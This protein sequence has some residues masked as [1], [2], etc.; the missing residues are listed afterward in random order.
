MDNLH[1]IELEF[2]SVIALAIMILIAMFLKEFIQ[3]QI[4]NIFNS[5]GKKFKRQRETSEIVY[6]NLSE[7][8][9]ISNG[10][11]SYVLQFHNGEHFF[12]DN[13][14]FKITQTY[15]TTAPGFDKG[16]KFKDLDSS[17]VQ[18]MVTALFGENTDTIQGIRKLKI[19]HP[20]SDIISDSDEIYVGVVKELNTNKGMTKTIMQERGVE[21][22]LFTPIR[23]INKEIVGILAVSY[24]EYD[25]WDRINNPNFDKETIKDIANTIGLQFSQRRKTFFTKLLGM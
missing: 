15:V 19:K 25:Y 3:N 14:R 16:S 22:F 9:S 7:L 20:I 5:Y 6:R 13:P 11:R 18:D 24:C 4:S 8:R 17:L 10:S 2:W 23:S 12:P 1:D 21:A